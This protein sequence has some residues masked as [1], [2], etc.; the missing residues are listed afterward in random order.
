MITPRSLLR[1][2][3]SILVL[4]NESVSILSSGG[5]N[6]FLI[7]SLSLIFSYMNTQYKIINI[8]IIILFFFF[9]FI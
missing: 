7:I 8:I 6:P 5:E 2:I 4:Y 9:F 1:V 3:I